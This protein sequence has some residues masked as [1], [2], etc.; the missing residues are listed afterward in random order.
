MAS[1]LVAVGLWGCGSTGVDQVFMRPEPPTPPAAPAARPAAADTIG[2][3]GDEA[4]LAQKLLVLPF[5]DASKYKGPWP[6][7]SGVAAAVADSLAPNKFYRVIGVASA[8]PLLTPEEQSGEIN[9]GRAIAVGR[10]LEADWVV[11]GEI[12][13]LTMRRFRAT[14]PLGGYRSY[15][16]A[17][18]VEISLIK[19]VDGT[20]ADP[21]TAEGLVDSKRTGITN[22][23]AFVPLDKQY[24]F[25]GDIEWGSE[26]FQQSLVGQA[27]AACAARVAEGVAGI[28]RPPPSL[29]V[30]QPKIVDIDGSSAYI[31]IGLAEGIQNGDK[32]GVWD[33]GRELRD[34][35]T[36]TVL[37]Y[38]LPRRVG[39]VQVEQVLADH[40]SQVRLLQGSD[41]VRAGFA[42]R[43]E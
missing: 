39:A 11:T 19:T 7:Q 35:E 24:Y 23:A 16:A 34:P 28:V 2:L 10:F 8:L 40:L 36:G 42:L 21:F 5:R 38:A 31:N 14:V 17:A 13:E 37:G 27:L 6:I 33:N 12:Q 26:E 22:P 20:R 15:E 32:F 18:A 43:A 4:V 9:A 41:E 1:A 25:W 30:S 3:V 29:A